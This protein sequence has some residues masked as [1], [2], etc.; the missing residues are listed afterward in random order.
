M[1]ATFL[2]MFHGYYPLSVVEIM[3]TTFRR[4]VLSLSLWRNQPANLNFR[5]WTLSL[6]DVIPLSQTFTT[7]FITVFT[8]TRH[9]T[10]PRAIWIQSVF[11]RSLLLLFCHIHLGWMH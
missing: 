6:Y 8:R 3:S 11:F 5:Q 2:K 1:S 4:L 10:L 9:W 7:T